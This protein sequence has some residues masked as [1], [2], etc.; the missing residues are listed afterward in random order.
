MMRYWIVLLGFCVAATIFGTL[1]FKRPI[2]AAIAASL[3]AAVGSGLYG[4]RS[5]P[6]WIVGSIVVLVCSLPIAIVA[7]IVTEN[8][9]ERVG[10]Q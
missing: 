1:A 6:L 2:P 3:L 8:V 4:A 9:S 5:S 7:A 10:R